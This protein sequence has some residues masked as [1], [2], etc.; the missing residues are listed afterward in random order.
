M[1]R[2]S[3]EPLRELTRLSATD[4]QPEPA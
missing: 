2:S 3:G 1:T 4:F